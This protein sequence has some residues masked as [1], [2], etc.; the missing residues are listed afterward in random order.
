MG[1]TP[2]LAPRTVSQVWTHDPAADEIFT[3]FRF[4]SGGG[5]VLG[6]YATNTAT[7]ADSGASTN[8]LAVYLTKY[9]SAATPVL[10][11]TLGV[12][13][14]ASPW[15]VDI[16]RAAS[17]TS[18]GSTA[19]FTSGEW[20]RLSYDENDLATWTEMGFQVD[21]VLAVDSNIVPTAA[22]GPSED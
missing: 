20:V 18:F 16:P 10:Q 9:S 15:G 11:G 1:F 12:W 8:Y 17:I 2:I 5:R 22:T 4:P 21:Y 6:A 13:T 14:G 3:I 19:I 7:I